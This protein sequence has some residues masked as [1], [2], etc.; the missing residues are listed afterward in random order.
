MVLFYPTIKVT[1][2]QLRG[3]GEKFWRKK[4]RLKITGGRNKKRILE[5]KK[6]V[7]QK[8]GTPNYLRI[9]NLIAPVIQKS[10]GAFLFFF[11]AFVPTQSVQFLRWKDVFSPGPGSNRRVWSQMSLWP[12]FC[13]YGAEMW[14]SLENMF[15]CLVCL[16]AGAGWGWRQFQLM[17]HVTV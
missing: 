16:F 3:A 13:S 10:G 9:V 1:I 14:T 15:C 4:T 17:S 12:Y 2:L 11:L 7:W 5:N 8:R 6:R